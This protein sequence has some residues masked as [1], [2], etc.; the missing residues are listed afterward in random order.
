MI[1]VTNWFYEK[2][3]DRKKYNKDQVITHFTKKQESFRIKNGQAVKIDEP[4]KK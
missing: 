2:S 1:K 3:E 4:K